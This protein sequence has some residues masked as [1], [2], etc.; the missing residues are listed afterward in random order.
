MTAL[1]NGWTLEVVSEKTKDDGK[2][3]LVLLR[4]LSWQLIVA[5]RNAWYEVP[6]VAAHSID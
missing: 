2:G 1:K 5:L 6:I 4:C 3:S